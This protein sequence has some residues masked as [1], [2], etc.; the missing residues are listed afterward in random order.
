M[1]S[2]TRRFSV[3]GRSAQRVATSHSPTAIAI[4]MS[5]FQRPWSPSERFLTSFM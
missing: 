2:I 4:V 1:A 5:S 3:S